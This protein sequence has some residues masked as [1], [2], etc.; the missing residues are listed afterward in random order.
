MDKET[1][2]REEELFL[3]QSLQIVCGHR[4]RIV[5]REFKGR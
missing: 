2:K 4:N 5:E 3:R 1:K